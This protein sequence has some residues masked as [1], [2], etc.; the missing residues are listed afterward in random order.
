MIVIKNDDADDLIQLIYL[1]ELLFATKSYCLAPQ[2]NVP[3]TTGGHF[4]EISSEDIF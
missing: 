3:R 1:L 4:V 2:Y